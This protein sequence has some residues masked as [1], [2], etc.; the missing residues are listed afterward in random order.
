MFPRVYGGE[1]RRR[2]DRE[3][4]ATLVEL[5]VATVL[6]GMV[7][8]ISTG[9]FFL[10]MRL[11]RTTTAEIDSQ[12]AITRVQHEIIDGTADAPGYLSATDLSF[13]PDESDPDTC[14]FWIEYH[15]EADMDPRTVEYRWSRTDQT[16][17]R[18]IG[19]KEGVVLSNIVEFI[20]RVGGDPNMLQL[21]I[22]YR[23]EDLKEPYRR[24]VEGKPRNLG[25]KGV[26]LADVIEQCPGA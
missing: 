12:M 14:V 9:I 1:T 5:L 15:P 8:Y 21:G 22:A 24:W 4:G 10:A 2:I 6:V 18:V 19:G 23:H 26:V 16:V 3:R 17:K 20:V 11:V 25:I 7:A 13:R